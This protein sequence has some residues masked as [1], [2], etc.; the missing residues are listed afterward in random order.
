LYLQCCALPNDALCQLADKRARRLEQNK[1]NARVARSR[2]KQVSG[3]LL[4]SRT[5]STPNLF[6]F[7]VRSLATT[8]QSRPFPLFFSSSLV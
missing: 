6:P 1:I 4:P 2:K 8:F 7:G 3:A 5:L